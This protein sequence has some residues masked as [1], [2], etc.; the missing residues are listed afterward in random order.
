MKLERPKDKFGAKKPSLPV[1]HAIFSIRIPEKWQQDIDLIGKK[2]KTK[3][4][5]IINQMLDWAIA[6]QIK[7]LGETRK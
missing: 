1:K 4:N 7:K 5:D 2:T 3:R 6:D